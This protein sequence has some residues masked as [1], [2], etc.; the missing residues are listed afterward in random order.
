MEFGYART[1]IKK[2]E[3][4]TQLDELSRYEI[5][6]IVTE[7]ASGKKS[8][9]KELNILL[10]KLRSGDTLGRTMYELVDLLNEFNEKNLISSP[11]K[12]GLIHLKMGLIH[13][14]LWGDFSFISLGHYGDGTLSHRR[15]C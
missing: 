2:Q 1:S 6:K 14:L 7:K 11:L 12:M 5:D 13:R 9:R 4:Q 10:G 3:L 8:D 15:T